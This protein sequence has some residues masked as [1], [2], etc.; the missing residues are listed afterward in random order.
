MSTKWT[1]VHV[2][3]REGIREADIRVKTYCI[4]ANFILY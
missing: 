1:F 2:V 4:R 3:W